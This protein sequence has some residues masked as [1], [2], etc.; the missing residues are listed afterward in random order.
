MNNQLEKITVRQ[1][2]DYTMPSPYTNN[3]TGLASQLAT[4]DKNN[5]IQFALLEELG[6]E[7]E[8]VEE[9]SIDEHRRGMSMLQEVLR[10]YFMLTPGQTKLIVGTGSTLAR[11]YNASTTMPKKIVNRLRP[12]EKSRDKVSKMIKLF[13]SK[14]REQVLNSLQI[15]RCKP[16]KRAQGEQTVSSISNKFGRQIQVNQK[17]TYQ[18]Q[19]KYNKIK[20]KV[21]TF[22]RK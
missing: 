22:R 17:K 11:L 5:Q 1:H 19:G 9:Y 13:E 20:A 2:T 18:T 4:G 15:G 10:R 7:L 21:D 12:L 14:Y 16:M 3:L 6:R 8:K